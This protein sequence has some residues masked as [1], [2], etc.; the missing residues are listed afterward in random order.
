M[1]KSTEPALRKVNP[2]SGTSRMLPNRLPLQTQISRFR[3]ERTGHSGTSIPR[4]MLAPDS[5]PPCEAD[6][7]PLPCA[8]TSRKSWHDTRRDGKVYDSPNKVQAQMQ[9]RAKGVAMTPHTEQSEY[10][11]S[12]DLTVSVPN[13]LA[14]LSACCRALWPGFKTRPG[15]AILLLDILLTHI[16]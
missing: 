8:S 13:F 4:G 7:L 6:K 5:T 1:P 11:P 12:V 3:L 10:A 16:R 14:L 2:R 9:D 15:R